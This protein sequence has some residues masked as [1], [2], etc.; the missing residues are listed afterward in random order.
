MLLFLRWE[1]A[2]SVLRDLETELT[3]ENK[4]AGGFDVPYMMAVI[5]GKE[6]NSSWKS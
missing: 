4:G 6:G 1:H 3:Q 5:S 2:S